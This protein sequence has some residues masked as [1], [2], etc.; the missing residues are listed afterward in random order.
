MKKILWLTIVALCTGC[1]LKLR[2]AQVELPTEYIYGS[3]S[4]LRNSS[5]P[6][7]DT[8]WES[9]ADPTLNELMI[10]ALRQ[11]H[12]LAAAAA[13]VE[14][15]RHYLKVARAE[16]L[17]SVDMEAIAE[18]THEEKA[19]SQEYTIAPYLEWEVSL[20]GALRNTKRSA[21]ASLMQEEWTLKGVWLS[22]S[23]EVATSYFTLLQY[24]RSHHI[25]K[26]SYELRRTATALVDSMYRYGMS[27]GTDLMQ[28]KSLVYSAK[29]EMQKYERAVATAS[30]SLNTLLGNTP[31][32]VD[33]SD[34]GAALIGDE[35]PINI[36]IGLP[37]SLLERR[38]DVMK[39]YYAMQ[40][41]GAQV[42]ISRA[43]RYPTITLTG[44][45]GV[46]ATSLEGLT[47]GNPLLWSATGELIAP[48]FSWG[49]LR[50]K[51]LIARQEYEA[52]VQEYEQSILEALSDVEKALIT[53]ST[54]SSE[55]A[56]TTALVLANS[57]IAQ[58][59]TALYRSG[60][61]DYLSVIDAERELYS[62]QI[63]LVEIVAQQYINYID[64]F[65]ALGGG[66]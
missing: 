38:P 11:N 43:A 48:L 50:R 10:I 28:A 20:F 65:K 14:A 24:Q 3:D 63:S 49:S 5:T 64:L 31:R 27:N 4:G 23:T 35:L 15:S 46:F 41:A 9:F 6:I 47:S 59:S 62:S 51:E 55:T 13:A 26:R 60:L 42:G 37:S 39:S 30:L 34:T 57:K 8:W 7:S 66:W 2:D 25:A 12:D 44:S 22:L 36:P 58:N 40:K 54:Y 1:S 45:G 18:I 29:I 16:F 32:T 56:A 33:W 53:I 61:G 17:P 19:T 21:I 52:S